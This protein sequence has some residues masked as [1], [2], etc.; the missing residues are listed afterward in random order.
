MPT[1]PFL[2]PTV[3]ITDPDDPRISEYRDLTDAALRTSYEAEHGLFVA[4][5]SLVL[6]RLIVS[7]L[8][9]RSVLVSPHQLDAHRGDLERSLD[10][11]VVVY[12]AAHDV[13][14][15]VSGFSV[16]RG[17]LAAV[18]RPP[19]RSMADLLATSER[20][21]VCE[22]IN[23][24][25]NLGSIF[26]NASA[27]G[28]DAVLLDPRC[29]DPWYRRCVRVSM[30]HVLTIPHARIAP[31]A[32]PEALT[33]IA[34]AGYTVVALTPDPTAEPITTVAA[35]V[36]PP[37]ALMVGAEGPGLSDAALALAQHRA[38]IP[39]TAGTDSLNVAAASAVAFHSFAPTD[40]A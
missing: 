24:H 14:A 36:R 32:W 10:R 33:H 18:D 39:M 22:A 23:D 26:R 2:R 5:G 3:T 30:G 11:G 29:S 38:R 9:I 15:G 25:T 34:G 40:L 20:V 27:L 4:E 6:S 21:V 7:G 16:H 17:V 19:P 12:V 37:L 1:H 8:R 28:I 35:K 13:L 31:E